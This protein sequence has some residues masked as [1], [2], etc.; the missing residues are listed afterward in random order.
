NQ[1]A[2]P[3]VPLIAEDPKTG[4]RS[5]EFFG[6]L[7][8]LGQRAAELEHTNLFF[9]LAPRRFSRMQKSAV[10]SA[11]TCHVDIDGKAGLR[12]IRAERPSAII[13]SSR[14]RFHVYWWLDKPIRRS[15]FRS[16]EQINRSIAQRLNGDAAW[17]VS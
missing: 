10:A 5:T 8:L 13:E 4:N 14:N 2:G 17:D 9:G 16:V 3:Y 15:Y 6:T 11:L 1:Y 7:D 12:Q